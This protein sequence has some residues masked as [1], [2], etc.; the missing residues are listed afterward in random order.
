MPPNQRV[1]FHDG[2]SGSRVNEAGQDD[3][4]DPCGIVARRDLTQR[5]ARRASCFRR[6]RFSAASRYRERKPSYTNLRT[7]SSRQPGVRRAMAKNDCFRMRKHATPGGGF[8]AAW[9]GR[10]M[11]A[12][13]QAGRNICGS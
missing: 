11:R 2:E 4:R 9:N 8:R 1:W 13:F 3:E 7:S 6:N 12:E 5:S 10:L